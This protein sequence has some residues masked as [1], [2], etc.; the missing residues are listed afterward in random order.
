MQSTLKAD[1]LRDF[2]EI[3]NPLRIPI[4][5]KVYTIPAIGARS[6]AQLRAAARNEPA[7]VD[8]LAEPEAFY[9]ALLGSAY[10]EMLADDAP[11]NAVDRAAFAAM[12][13]FQHGR[14]AAL[15]AWEAGQTPEALAVILTATER[16]AKA[17]G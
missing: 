13:D 3:A 11:E 15:M 5:G 12:A 10:E 4:G 17:D 8:A 7:A 16:L 14:V 2:D 9:R 1:N 6:A